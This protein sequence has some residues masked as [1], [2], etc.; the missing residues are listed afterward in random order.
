[1]FRRVKQFWWAIGVLAA[2]LLPWVLGQYWLNMVILSL[3]FAIVVFSLNLLNG[4]AGLLSFGQAAFVGLGA[5][6]LGVL[7]VHGVNPFLA[8]VAG[9]FTATA[10]GLLIALPAARLKG[11]YL[12]I[13]TL[14]FGVLIFQL[15]LNLEI[16][17]GP[18]GLSGIPTE[19]V[20]QTGWYYIVLSIVIGLGL[21]LRYLGDR[22][23]LGI[24]LKTVKAD[25]V[26]AKSCGINVFA[27]KLLAF[28]LSA[29]LAGLAG[30]LYG[31]YLRF[32]TPELFT[33][34]QSFQFLMMSVVGGTG[35][36]VGGLI[37]SLIFT[38]LPEAL[39][40][41]GESNI[42]LLIYG[43]AVLSVLLFLPDGIGGLLDKQRL[44]RAAK[45]GSQ[46]EVEK[47]DGGYRS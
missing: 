1:M 42:R 5:Y 27:V 22:S 15:L 2:A 21:V 34:N 44:F 12:A 9:V 40:V 47:I 16:T 35:S 26:A 13:G 43:I 18:M 45:P 28:G 4:L 32:L 7:S 10:A 23:L 29:T 14:G 3:I 36:F 33:T 6:I 31:A 8:T 30:A 24:M 25:E 19:G 20:P 39:R 11:H 46:K 37:S 17:R 41:V 38:I